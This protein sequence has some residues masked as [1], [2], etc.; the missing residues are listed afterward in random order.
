MNDVIVLT[1]EEKEVF[2]QLTKP[3]YSI[4]PSQEMELYLSMAKYASTKIPNRIK[5]ILY[6][7]RKKSTESGILLFKK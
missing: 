5:K 3:L 2:I 1:E 4:S 6:E 7:F